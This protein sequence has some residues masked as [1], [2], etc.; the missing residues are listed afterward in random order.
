MS[1]L[2][3]VALRIVA[4]ACLCFT[5]AVAWVV[6]DTDRAVQIETEGTANRVARQLTQF[7]MLGS[8]NT[9]YGPPFT[10]RHSIAIVAVMSPGVCVEFNAPVDGNRRLCSGWNG[11]G[12]TAPAW[13]SRLFGQWFSPGAPIERPVVVLGQPPVRVIATHDPV[14]ATTRAWHQLRV[15]VGLVAAMAAGIAVLSVLAIGHALA[16]TRRIIAG[17]KR[18]EQGDYASRLPAFGA[19]EF[20]RISGAA[21]ELAA[22][23]AVTTAERTALTQ[24]LFEVQETERR[25]LARDLHDEFGQ[26]LT[27]TGALAASLAAA[28]PAERPDLADDARAI[29]RVTARMMATLKNALARLR[30]PELDEVGLEAS[31]RGMV[32]AWNL[33]GAR[34][35]AFRLDIDGDLAGL[36]PDDA[37]NVYRIAQE[38]LTN[39]ARHSGASAVH[40]HV[41]RNPGGEIAVIVDDDGEGDPAVLASSTGF[42]I[43]GIRERIG[44]LGGSFGVVRTARGLRIEARFAAAPDGSRRMA[45]A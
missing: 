27:A 18:L 38:C 1:L 41:A 37:L 23:L 28:A 16:P 7:Y 25:A 31:L 32:A 9:F 34:S 21:N 11:L 5:L 26:C 22:K 12:R 6:F 36:A 19:A 33:P 44:A 20:N 4:V 15:V 14:A 13:F 42:G 35:A 40:L 30:P 43:L 3:A 10:A 39:A 17:L 45:A 24:R 29:G 8:S 2:L